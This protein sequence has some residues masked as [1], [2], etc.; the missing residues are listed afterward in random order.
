MHRVSS[1]QAPFGQRQRRAGQP[2]T[3][4]RELQSRAAQRQEPAG[5]PPVRTVC[6]ALSLPSRSPQQ[7]KLFLCEQ[8]GSG[9][10]AIEARVGAAHAH[11]LRCVCACATQLCRSQLLTGRCAEHLGGASGSRAE[12]KTADKK[13]GSPA[14]GARGGGAGNQT[15]LVV[16]PKERL[17]E[18]LNELAR[19]LTTW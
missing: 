1:P 12:K 9:S 3:P 5:R 14:T 8:N 18:V 7:L 16:V 13:P 10:L 2:A 19:A 11:G 4:R 15:Q 17:T 6:F